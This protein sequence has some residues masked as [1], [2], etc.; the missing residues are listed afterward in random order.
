MPKSH[1]TIPVF[2]PNRGCPRRC[3]FCDQGASGGA[4]K[5][6][7]PEEA[8]VKI[9]AYLE[10]MDPSVPRVEAAFF[11]GNFTGLPRAEQESYLAAVRP[12]LAAGRV[13]GI[14][15]STRPDCIDMDAVEF[16]A[17]HGVDT[18]ELGVQSLSDTVLAAA[19]RD[20]TAEDV[21]RAVDILKA[22]GIPVILQLMAGLPGDSRETCLASAR[23]AAALRPA[24][25][26]IFPAVVLRGTELERI[27][28]AGGYVPL[29]LEEAVDTCAA[30]YDIFDKYGVPVIRTGLHPLRDAAT[31]VTAGPYHT[32]F[33]FL[34]KSRVRR[35]V[36][37]T[38]LE[39]FIAKAGGPV[40]E[41]VLIIPRGN[42]EEYIGH[43][44]ENISY[45]KDAFQPG[46]LRVET[47]DVALP[48]VRFI[49]AGK[50]SL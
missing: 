2:L 26:R 34:V 48:A 6:S 3:V 38:V 43:G 9:A 12:F 11:G 13:H 23:E 41:A 17:G 37:E 31:Q 40:R 7:T 15:V 42:S 49:S 27:Y 39:E 35:R 10:T 47:G 22:A 5:P 1:V 24:G 19:H 4:D 21:F 8:R 25:A 14:R 16:L 50:S 29:T 30:M 36:M 44:R 45:L 18:V 32:A 28:R 20:H 46:V 33:G